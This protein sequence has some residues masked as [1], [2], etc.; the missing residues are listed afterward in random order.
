MGAHALELINYIAAGALLGTSTHCFFFNINSKHGLGYIT[1]LKTLMC[2]FFCV[3]PLT[4]V[5]LHLDLDPTSCLIDGKFNTASFHAA[6]ICID[7]ILLSR[8]NVV[9]GRS[10]MVAKVMSMIWLGL[11]VA[12]ACADCY[13]SHVTYNSTLGICAYNQNYVTGVLYL[14]NDMTIDLYVS[15][16]I[17]VKLFEAIKA[18]KKMRVVGNVYSVL[19]ESNLFR[20]IIIFSSNFIQFLAIVLQFEGFWLL[21]FWSLSDLAYLYLITYD[22]ALIR[23]MSATN[24]SRNGTNGQLTSINQNNIPM[25]IKQSVHV[26]GSSY[27]IGDVDLGALRV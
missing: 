26:S 2:F 5:F 17:C 7:A 20:T 15:S 10:S 4:S 19:I 21:I 8:A 24:N 22:T 11:R 12:V 25:T 18:R 27:P 1:V 14:I 3:E 6:M 9:L 23:F 13:F 16:A